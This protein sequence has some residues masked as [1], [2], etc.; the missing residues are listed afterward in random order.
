MVGASTM[1]SSNMEGFAEVRY[2]IAD[3]DFFG[4]YAGVTYMLK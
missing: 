2:N 4:I 1:L 3:V